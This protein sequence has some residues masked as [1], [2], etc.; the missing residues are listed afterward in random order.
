M[1]GALRIQ[2][3]RER[4]LVRLADA[5][6]APLRWFGAP[7]PPSAVRRI[8]LLRLERI[9]DLLMAL[10]AIHDVHVAWP[11][12]EID[13]AVGSWNTSLASL[14][15]GVTRVLAADAPWLARGTPGDDWMTLISKVREWR[16][17]EYDLVIN[18]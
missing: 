14:V 16:T 18:F 4:G 6:L 7:R 8:L 12:A 17:H 3:A 9:G 13:L 10:E 15:P 11:E 5:M 2:N 1:A